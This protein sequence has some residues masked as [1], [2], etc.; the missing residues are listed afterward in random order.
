MSARSTPRPGV[1]GY[2]TFRNPVPLPR[3][4]SGSGHE[5]SSLSR[6]APPSRPVSRDSS[7]Q[8]Q[9]LFSDFFDEGPSHKRHSSTGGDRRP[10]LLYAASS[11][12]DDE[13][14]SVADDASDSSSS[15]SEP[16][17][18]AGDLESASEAQPLLETGASSSPRRS[19][20]PSPDAASVRPSH[21][22]WW[23]STLRALGACCLYSGHV[24]FRRM[25]AVNPSKSIFSVRLESLH[26]L[27]PIVW[28]MTSLLTHVAYGLLYALF[29]SIVL[30]ARNGL[31]LEWFSLGLLLLLALVK[32]SSTVFWF[33]GRVARWGMAQITTLCLSTAL[34]TWWFALVAWGIIEVPW[35]W[36]G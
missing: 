1:V 28:R 25:Y 24:V 18:R 13:G 19:R 8:Q 22:S 12:G 31:Q 10:P 11:D 4:L 21:L 33:G 15:W 34:V 3:S 26:P 29:P 32:G 27:Y 17:P 2:G 30:R 16:S 7:S 35:D 36:S 20:S 23:W 6:S 5:P 9:A 14:S